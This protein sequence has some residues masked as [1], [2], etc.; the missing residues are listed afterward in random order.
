MKKF[1]YESLKKRRK[2]KNIP[3]ERTNR[4]SSQFLDD[5]QCAHCS[6]GISF[7]FLSTYL[8]PSFF[9]RCYFSSFG[10]LLGVFFCSV[11]SSFTLDVICWFEIFCILFKIFRIWWP[12]FDSVGGSA[13]LS[14]LNAFVAPFGIMSS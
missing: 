7:V 9:F 12:A 5:R 8:L 14:F 13:R 11:N 10:I 1:M 3:D 6:M 2:G 4:T